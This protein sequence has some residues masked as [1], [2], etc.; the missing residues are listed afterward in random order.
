MSAPPLV[1]TIAEDTELFLP[2]IPSI[3]EVASVRSPSPLSLEALRM[4][5]A[6]K[7]DTAVAAVTARATPT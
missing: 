3:R 7:K 2:F 6:T 1:P 4:I 5:E